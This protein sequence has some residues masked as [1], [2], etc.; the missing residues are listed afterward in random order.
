MEASFQYVD[1]NNVLYSKVKKF[2]GNQT[3]KDKSFDTKIRIFS[4]KGNLPAIALGFRDLGGTNL[5]GAE[6]IA[7][8]KYLNNFDLTF[9]LGWGTLN[10]NRINNPFKYISNRFENRGNPKR[11]GGQ[12]S[13]I[14]I[15]VVMQD[16]S[17]ELSTLYQS[18]M[19]QGLN[20]N[21]TVLIIKLR[22]LSL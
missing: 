13:T 12:F 4:E 22:Q 15:S 1:I 8:S 18:F 2:S 11:G 21:M 10:G 19:V 9:G 7:L 5:F 6:Y 14:H 20:L 16:T 3:L 17:E